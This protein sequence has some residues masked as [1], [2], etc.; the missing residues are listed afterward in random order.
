MIKI[1]KTFVILFFALTAPAAAFAADN[2]NSSG[3]SISGKF[4][5]VSDGLIV[6]NAKGVRKS[7]IRSENK[8][9]VYSDY[10][11]YTVSPF[12]KITE[13]TPC[14]IVFLDTF[15]VKFKTPDSNIIEMQRYRVK[16]LEINIR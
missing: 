5:S 8:Y 3:G 6:I 15:I 2:L 4:E 1:L 14:K 13:S 16:D 11:T 9:D 12:S 7:Y 10:I